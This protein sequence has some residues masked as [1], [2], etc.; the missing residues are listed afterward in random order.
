MCNLWRALNKEANNKQQLLTT[1]LGN[2]LFV[3]NDDDCVYFVSIYQGKTI[4]VN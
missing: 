2:A 1:T 4:Y 3:E